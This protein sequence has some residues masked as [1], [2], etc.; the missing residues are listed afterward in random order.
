MPNTGQHKREFRTDSAPQSLTGIVLEIELTKLLFWISWLSEKPMLNIQCIQVGH[1]K[2][3]IYFIDSK[4]R[5]KEMAAI[6][7][8][9]NDRDGKCKAHKIG[10][11]CCPRTRE[12]NDEFF[13]TCIFLDRMSK[14]SD[15]IANRSVRRHVFQRKYYVDQLIFIIANLRHVLWKNA[16]FPCSDF[17]RTA[18]TDIKSCSTQRSL[19]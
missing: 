18:Y 14:A 6:C 13:C 9:H 17:L 8:R 12:N 1:N 19:H 15:F 10:S 11:I 7:I 5:R 16:F 2:W 4:H 3:N